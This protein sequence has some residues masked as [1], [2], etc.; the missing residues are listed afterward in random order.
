MTQVT[1]SS[2]RNVSSRVEPFHVLSLALPTPPASGG[3]SGTGG[4]NYASM[5]SSSVYETGVTPM[6]AA[7]AAAVAAAGG[8]GT[9]LLAC[10]ASACALERLEGDSAYF[11]ERCRTKRTATKRLL[12]HMLPPALVV[13]VNR[14]Q[15]G[16]KSSAKR[17]K[18]QT[19]VPFPLTLTAA[20]D[21]A[22][23]LS[24]EAAAAYCGA[25]GGREGG[26][27]YRLVAVVVHQGRGID[28]GHYTAFCRDDSAD[29]WVLYDDH[30]VAIRSSGEVQKAQAYLL[31]YEMQ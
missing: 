24:T 17:E 27:V 5:L 8:G 9:S 25:G 23:F 11:C 12:L 3:G 10:L 31:F 30:T 15:W 29:A 21:L 4:F 13:H 6:P 28:T 1:C 20:S 18:L 19:H 26:V 22:P 16:W 7:H 14:A 2:C